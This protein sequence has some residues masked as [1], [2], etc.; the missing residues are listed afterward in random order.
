MQPM[1][2][3]E[4]GR[5]LP[6]RPQGFDAQ[7]FQQFHL[8]DAVFQAVGDGLE[9]VNERLFTGRAAPGIRG[10]RLVI[11]LPGFI[12]GILI[13]REPESDIR[14]LGDIDTVRGDAIVLGP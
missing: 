2:P 11:R 14:V 3:H 9:H 7:R 8:L 5:A 13:G 12:L 6:S 10:Q 4:K 1:G